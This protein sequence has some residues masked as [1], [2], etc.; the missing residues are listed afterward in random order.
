MADGLP[1]RPSTRQVACR[2]EHLGVTSRTGPLRIT[3]TAPRKLPPNDA[4]DVLPIE[5]LRG[6]RYRGAIDLPW[7]AKLIN[8]DA[9]SGR[10][11]CSL[12]VELDVAAVCKHRKNPPCLVCIVIC[13]GDEESLRLLEIRG[14]YIRSGHFNTFQVQSGV[15]YLRMPPMINCGRHRGVSVCKH[16]Y[17]ATPKNPLVVFESGPALTVEANMRTDPHGSVLP[18]S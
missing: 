18:F 17:D 5:S 2:F 1:G 12:K 13:D 8:E 11:E 10:P 14:K 3:R 7:G 15:H 4:N 9:E 6:R 16:R